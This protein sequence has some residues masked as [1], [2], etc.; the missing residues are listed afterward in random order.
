MHDDLGIDF[1]IKSFHFGDGYSVNYY[2]NF[3]VSEKEDI[4]LCDCYGGHQTIK[5]ASDCAVA[6]KRGAELAANRL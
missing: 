1:L 4:P 6:L 3:F 5:E 2:R